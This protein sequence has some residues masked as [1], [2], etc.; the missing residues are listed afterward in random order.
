MNWTN[1]GLIAAVVTALVGAA[2]AVYRSGPQKDLD[3][4]TKKKIEIEIK[5]E[6]DALDRRRTIRLLRLEKY[7]DQDIQYHRQVKNLLEHAKAAGFLPS[8]T[9]IPEP[10]DLPQVDVDG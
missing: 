4:S 6:A 9:V 3:T 1:L 2:V 7:V 10:P 8:D 5:R